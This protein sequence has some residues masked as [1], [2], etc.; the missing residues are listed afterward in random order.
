VPDAS[1]N[2]LHQ[3]LFE[4]DKTSRSIFGKRCPN[5]PVLLNLPIAVI[6]FSENPISAIW[7]S[8]NLPFSIE[9][10]GMERAAICCWLHCTISTSMWNAMP[11]ETLLLT[12]AESGMLELGSIVKL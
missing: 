9:K 2:F 12:G 6:P 8:E 1:F 4:N 10:N 7:D 11:F 5:L 3:N